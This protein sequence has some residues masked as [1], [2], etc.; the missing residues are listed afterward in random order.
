MVYGNGECILSPGQHPDFGCENPDYQSGMEPM[1]IWVAGDALGQKGDVRDVV[2]KGKDAEIRIS[3]KTKHYA[4]K[5]SRL[6]GKADFVKTWGLDPAGCS[7]EYWG[8]V[9]PVFTEL[10]QIKK[11]R[12]QKLYGVIKQKFQNAFIGKSWMHLKRRFTQTT[13]RS[14]RRSEGSSICHIFVTPRP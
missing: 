8:A 4:F 10:D 2:I 5:H 14:H 1:G 7:V 3:C 6:S 12:A 9:K 13:S 11:S